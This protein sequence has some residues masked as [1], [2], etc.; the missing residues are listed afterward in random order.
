MPRHVLAS[1][2]VWLYHA[3]PA[4]DIPAAFCLFLHAIHCKA[5]SLNASAP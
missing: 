1:S 2:K 3:T 5:P 4:G